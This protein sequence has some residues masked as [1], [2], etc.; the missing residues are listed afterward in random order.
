[1][2]TRVGGVAL[3]VAATLSA[4]PR[5]NAQQPP[6]QQ[7]NP[8]P[9]QQYSP[10]PPPAQ[11]GQPAY[12]Q[13]PAGQVNYGPQQYQQYPYGQPQPSAAP[14]AP[15]NNQRGS[16]EMGLLYGTSIAYGVGT[17]VWVDAL[18]GV[19]DPGLAFIAPVAFGAAMPVAAYFVDQSDALHKGVPASISTGLMLGAV[20]GLAI[21]GVQWQATGNNGPNTW[22]FRT[23]TTVTFLTATGGGVGGYFFGEWLHPDPRSLG[24]VASGAGWGALAGTLLGAGITPR[25][26]DWKDG[27]SV[28]GLV[29][30]NAGI[31]ATG[32]L[33]TIYTPSWKSQKYMWLGELAGTGASSLV[34][35][36]YAFTPSAPVWHGLIANSVG[37]LAGVGLAAA[38][39]TDLRD[40][41]APLPPVAQPAA[42]PAAQPGWQQPGA[43]PGYPPGTQP[44][45]PP[46]AQPGYPPPGTQPA[47]PPP[48]PR[49]G[50]TPPFQIGVARLPEGG[51]VVTA[52]GSF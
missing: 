23:Q 11:Y 3:A 46:G 25:G 47:A 20:E 2:T 39:T 13:P 49:A 12:G 50:F 33:S 30:Y 34:Y 18:A 9:Q 4:A 37:G 5:A 32:A 19:S 15:A 48:P 45:Y 26:G 10:P 21:S 1:M 7:Y 36:F 40:D 16:G 29:G 51:A 28:A 44:A 43:R 38:L 52:Y 41:D 17:G 27:G 31:L 6:P 42:Q 22:S 8:P 35:L 14:T 24:F